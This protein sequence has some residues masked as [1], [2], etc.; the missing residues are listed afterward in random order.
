MSVS[1]E[2]LAAL[3]PE[4]KRIAE[5]HAMMAHPEG[6]FFV[7]TFRSVRSVD[8][9]DGRSPR[10]AITNILFLLDDN[11]KNGIS[12]FHRVVSDEIWI[13]VSG[14][15]LSVTIVDPTM[16]TAKSFTLDESHPTSTVPAAYWQAAQTRGPWTLVSCSVG[17]GFEFQDFAMLD[18]E[19]P[20]KAQ[21]IDSHPH[22]A[23]LA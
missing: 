17:P 3:H 1:D 2:I 9:L 23:S 15:P 19:P 4:A 13:H 7:E 8:P 12:R 22:L 18:D 16:K 6:G 5:R 21:L 10:S 11:V 14:A 20:L